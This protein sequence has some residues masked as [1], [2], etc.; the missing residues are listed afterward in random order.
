MRYHGSGQAFRFEG[1]QVD[2]E[3]LI[4]K[5]AKQG[6]EAFFRPSLTQGTCHEK[7]LFFHC[8]PI[9]QNACAAGMAS[10]RTE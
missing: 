3:A 1:E 9:R 8:S 2:I 7:Q 10:S 5:V 4:I 6:D